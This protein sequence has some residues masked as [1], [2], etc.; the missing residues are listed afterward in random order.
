[1]VLVVKSPPANA[2]DVRDLGSVSWW[3]RPPGGGYGNPLQ[4]SCLEN[5]MDRGTWWAIVHRVAKSWTWLKWLSTPIKKITLSSI[6]L[7]GKGYG[8]G[9][10]F[11]ICDSSEP[12]LPG[13]KQCQG[14]SD[15]LITAPPTHYWRTLEPRARNRNLPLKLRRNKALSNLFR[16]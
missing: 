14:V 2:G 13:R 8:H 11:L 7:D 4:Y 15:I 9:T 16:H 1:M 5:L 3:G 10:C 6:P 12:W